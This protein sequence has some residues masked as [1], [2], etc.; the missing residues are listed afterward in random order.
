MKSKKQ[1]KSLRER[2]TIWEQNKRNKLRLLKI[3]GLLKKGDKDIF[4][5]IHRILGGLPKK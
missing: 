2:K 1:F 5:P 4:E 3:K